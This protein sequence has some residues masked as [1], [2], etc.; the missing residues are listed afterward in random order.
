M[1]ADGANYSGLCEEEKRNEDQTVIWFVG[2]LRL[3]MTTKFC[4]SISRFHV[5]FMQ[6][7]AFLDE[8]VDMDWKKVLNKN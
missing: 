6:N 2:S 4:V 7:V 1:A 5:H 8:N 3:C